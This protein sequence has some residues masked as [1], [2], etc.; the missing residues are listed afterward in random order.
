MTLLRFAVAT[1]PDLGGDAFDEL[2]TILSAA[3][4]PDV[5][6]VFVPNYVSLF[7][8][9]HLHV[10]DAGWC[11]PLVARD[12][13]R[14]AA[15]D[16]VAT[17]L[18]GGNDH[19]YSAIVARPDSGIRHVSQIVQARVGWVSRM[20]AAGYVVPRDYLQSL[21]IELT[22]LD[23]RF[24]HTHGRLTHALL[25]G[26]VDVIGTYASAHDG[27][28]FTSPVLAQARILGVAGQIPGDVIVATRSVLR[29]GRELGAALRSAHVS[30]DGPLA[31][32]MNASGFGHVPPDHL[33]SLAR[34]VERSMTASFRYVARAYGD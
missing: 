3:G 27:R 28:F 8:T 6:P 4:G 21:G 26:D 16:P 30:A 5:E 18:R 31:A 13:V 20:S 19:Y 10:A 24:F 23:E 32:L 7:E 12:L 17:V 15:A 11:P 2:R 1:T 14:V 9:M 29:A 22:A 33:L 34:W 25:D